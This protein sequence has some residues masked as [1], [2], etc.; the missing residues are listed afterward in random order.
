MLRLL[1]LVGRSVVCAVCKRLD[2]PK[3]QSE[4]GGG[5]FF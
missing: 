2:W 4:G 1:D 3:K 5:N